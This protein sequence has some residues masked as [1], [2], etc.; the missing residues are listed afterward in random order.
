MLC[1][2]PRLFYMELSPYVDHENNP[3]KLKYDCDLYGPGEELR[4]SESC[5]SAPTTAVSAALF[6]TLTKHLTGRT[7]RKEVF[8]FIYF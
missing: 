1:P 2:Y 4:C 5:P 8:I 7:L 6:I 3:L